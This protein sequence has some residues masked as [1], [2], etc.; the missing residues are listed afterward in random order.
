MGWEVRW[1]VKEHKVYDFGNMQQLPESVK[2][3]DFDRKLASL[4]E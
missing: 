3:K 4:A 2:E 1:S